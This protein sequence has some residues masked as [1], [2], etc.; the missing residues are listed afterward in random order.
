MTTTEFIIAYIIGY[1]E[2]L[3]LLVLFGKK[4]LG[5]DYDNQKNKDYD[6]W[7]S[8]SQ[9]YVG[10]SF[11]WF[12]VWGFVIIAIIWKTLVHSTEYLMKLTNNY[13][14]VNKK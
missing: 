7:N 6:D 1:I 14:V 5:I 4:Y 12:M 9:A 8:N 11:V 2:T 10:W 3:I 13:E